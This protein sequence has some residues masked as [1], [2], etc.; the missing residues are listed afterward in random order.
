MLKPMLV[1]AA[2]G[3]STLAS[4][5][6]WPN[7]TPRV[8]LYGAYRDARIMF[9]VS[10]T[11]EDSQLG[12]HHRLVIT[13][14]AQVGN[15]QLPVVHNG[16]AFATIYIDSAGFGQLAISEV[17]GPECVLVLPVMASGDTITLGHGRAVLR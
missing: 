4:A 17:I 1:A 16:I 7:E 5:A 11:G 3:I 6:T 15:V 12:Y 14:N 13:A 9:D 2:V 10:Y 8:S